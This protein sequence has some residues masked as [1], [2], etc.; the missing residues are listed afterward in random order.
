MSEEIKA[1]LDKLVS[2]IGLVEAP[3][4][5]AQKLDLT[6]ALENVCEFLMGLRKTKKKAIFIGNGG[7]A[8]IAS[9][10][11]SDF[12]KNGRIRT[13]SFSDPS[14]LTCISNDLGYEHV[15]E[16]PLEM[17]ADQGDVLFAISSSGKSAN[18]IKAVEASKKLG[19]D[20]VTLS[21]FRS[22]NPLRKMGKTNFY[23]PS[24]EY[25][26]VESIHQI[27]CQLIVDT[28]MKR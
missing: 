24:S 27:I 9:H 18:I 20:V 19:L 4:D 8:G 17:L 13:L 14:L 2:L 5:K 11:S 25:G 16:K 26:F 6:D 1:Y 21:G 10:M 12:L 15:Y 28:I 23:V 3:D 22:D 7:S